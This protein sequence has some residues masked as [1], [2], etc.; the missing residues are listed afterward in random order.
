MRLFAEKYR[1][2]Y[3]RAVA[4]LVKDRDALLLFYDFPAE[5][6]DRL[7]TTNPIESV[8]ESGGLPRSMTAVLE[9]PFDGRIVLKESFS[10]GSGDP[11]YTLM[12][13][14]VCSSGDSS[15]ASNA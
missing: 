8:L 2:K 15:S 12:S 10:I 6:W 5:H 9:M 4:C 13:G 3:G 7:R 11:R 14:G 1:A